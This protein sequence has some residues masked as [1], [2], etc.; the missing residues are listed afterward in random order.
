MI[1]IVPIQ[2]TR[3]ELV[4]YCRRLQ[5][6]IDDPPFMTPDSAISGWRTALKAT[7]EQHLPYIDNQLAKARTGDVEA[8]RNALER[9]ELASDLMRDVVGYVAAASTSARAKSLAEDLGKAAAEVV[10]KAG[11]IVAETAAGAVQ[12]FVAGSGVGTLLLVVLLAGAAYFL[13]VRR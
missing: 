13:V 2:A 9:I 1:D 7:Q 3:D 10:N 6:D 11:E 8:A 12:G 5:R 4:E